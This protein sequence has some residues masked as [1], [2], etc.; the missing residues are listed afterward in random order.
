MISHGVDWDEADSHK[1]EMPRLEAKGQWQ[2]TSSAR[3]ALGVAG[4]HHGVIW[5]AV[6]LRLT[7]HLHGVIFLVA[8]GGEGGHGY[9]EPN[10]FWNPSICSFGR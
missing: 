2:V 8:S 1:K 3:R 6:S 7:W 5:G 4:I 10:D 9:P